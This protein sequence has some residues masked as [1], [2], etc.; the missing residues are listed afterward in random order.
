MEEEHTHGKG[1]KELEIHNK[2]KDSRKGRKTMER[3]HATKT[4]TANIPTTQNNTT[5]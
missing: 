5:L 2:R 1:S 4:Q 3:T